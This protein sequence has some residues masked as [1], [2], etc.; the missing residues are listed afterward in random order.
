MPWACGPVHRHYVH[1][2]FMIEGHRHFLG[3]PN[4]LDTLSFGASDKRFAICPRLGIWAPSFGLPYQPAPKR[5]DRYP[6]KPTFQGGNLD[7]G[8]LLPGR[9]PSAPEASLAC[10]GSTHLVMG[11]NAKRTPYVELCVQIYIYIL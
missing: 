11:P 9:E 6:Q 4:R 2:R 3:D 5:G 10:F 1:H 8:A 7:L